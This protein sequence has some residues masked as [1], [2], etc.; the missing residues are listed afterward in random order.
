MKGLLIKDFLLLRSYG[1]SL[2]LMFLLFLIIGATSGPAFIVGIVMIESVMLAVS[3][4]SYDDMAKWNSYMLAMP[5]SRKTAVREKYALAFLLS[6]IG[7][8]LSIAAGIAAGAL[9]GNIDLKE[10]AATV[11]GCF[12]AACLYVSVMIP[13]TYRFGA[14]KMRFLLLAVIFRPVFCCVRRICVFKKIRPRRVGGP[15]A[16]LADIPA[17]GRCCDCRFLFDFGAHLSEKRNLKQQIKT[18]SLL[19]V[20]ILHFFS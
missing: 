8:V 5:V 1:K 7:I 15:C 6:L 13:M 2:L 9:R 14:E 3:T 12:I 18:T 19:V 16:G 10:V 20:L 4:F 17:A 11:G